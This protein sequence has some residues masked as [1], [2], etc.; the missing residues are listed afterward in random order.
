MIYYLFILS[1]ILEV[2]NTASFNEKNGII[3]TENICNLP[4]GRCEGGDKCVCEK[5]FKQFPENSEPLCM[6]NQELASKYIF[7]ESLFGFGIGHF[8]VGNKIMG[9]IKL[10]LGLLCL[11]A[12]FVLCCL[13]K[14]YWNCKTVYR[15]LVYIKICYSLVA[16]YLIFYAVDVIL[17]ILNVY[18]DGNGVPL[19]HWS[20]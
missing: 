20:G 19:F 6:Y 9:S 12:I 17:I 7:Y 13:W 10:T 5:G 15:F 3:C 11:I 8:V 1:V 14:N 18:K 2:A 4:Y 16:L